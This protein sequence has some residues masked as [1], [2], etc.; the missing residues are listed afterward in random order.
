MS[1]LVRQFTLGVRKT[2]TQGYQ[3]LTD[4]PQFV[5]RFWRRP[6][7]MVV[8]LQAL[9][10]PLDPKIFVDRGNGFNE[11]TSISLSHA[12]ICIYSISVSTPRRVKGIRI[13]PCSNE[14]RFRY[15]IKFAW[16]KADLAKLLA[17]AK[18]DAESTASIYDVVIDGT[19]EK[20]KR[21]NSAIH[22]AEH[23]DS[24]IRLARHTAPPIEISITKDAP[25]ISF[26]VPVY[27][28]P[29]IYLNDL[30]ASFHQQPEGSAELI[31]SDDGSTS[32]RT[33][34]WLNAHTHVLGVRIIRNEENRGIAATTNS[35]IE[36]ARGEWISFVDHDDALTPCSVQ[37][38]AET[39]RR[40]PNCQ[41]I[42]TDE[43]V[44]DE[45]LKPVAYFFKPAYDEVLL[46]G[47]NYIN[48]LSCYKRKRLLALGGMR[49][50]YDG[51]QD[52]ELLLRY[53]RDLRPDEI[54]H[55]PYPA[56]QWRRSA[57]AF[58]AQFTDRATA[59]A[60]KA[61]AERY[62]RSGV[63]ATV[64]EAIAKT[65]HRVRFDKL[66]TPWPRVSI[67]IPNRDSFPFISRVLSDLAQR[68]SYPDFE[69]IVVDNGS[70]DRRVL[71]LYAKS[72]EGAIP[73]R[74][75]IDS[76][77]FNFSRQV[78]RGIA[79]ARG[80]L[81]LLLNSDIEIIE[82][83]WLREMASCFSYSNTGIVGAR[84]L[85]PSG[86]IQHA[87]I[88]IGLGGLAGHWFGGQRGDYPGPMARLHVRQS[89]S[90]VTGACMLISR[91]CLDAVG[92]FDEREFP[93]A[94]ND[95]DF[96]LRALSKGFRVVWTPFATL[97]H[98]ESAARGS[99]ETRANRARFERDKGS[100][101]RRH[102][103][104]T[105]E[106]RSFSPWYTRDRSEPLPTRLAQLPDAR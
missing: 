60:R 91:A 1:L 81:I 75:D 72:K 24:V 13:D 18:Q 51:S 101:R 57:S 14:E 102:A 69:I 104:E 85:Y 103:T 93:I 100:L 97:I 11:V 43:I 84:L 96:C 34:S 59:S 36:V 68:T 61:L 21:R 98:H 50:G 42:Y 31:L 95:I 25:F 15:W 45:K 49:T 20:R 44:T 53:I 87:G 39:A 23:F 26:I 77:P 70:T 17:E 105:F 80:E 64:D 54:K 94:Y 92:N 74:C 3:A 73:F 56:Y 55:L 99:D 46:S 52:Y 22:V 41:F 19:P 27:N 4:D 8:F 71:D 2:S 40:H 76:V 82:D 90:A 79:L 65:L 29:E 48:H 58:S 7:Y 38:I 78:N 9:N 83:N 16:N 5:Y 35:G 32:A 89:Y 66:Q 37:L 47:V 10:N 6:R 30:L 106:D 63:E 86:R 28:T 62:C 12:G 88:V 67:I 33:L